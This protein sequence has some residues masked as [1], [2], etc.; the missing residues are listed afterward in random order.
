MAVTSVL[1][2]QSQLAARKTSKLYEHQARILHNLEQHTIP[3]VHN[4]GFESL[5]AFFQALISII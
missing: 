2:L 5:S 3:V 1:A 4:S